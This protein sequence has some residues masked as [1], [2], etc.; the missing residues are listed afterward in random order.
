VPTEPEFADVSPTGKTFH[1]RYEVVRRIGA[2]GMAVVYQVLDRVTGRDRALKTMLPGIV[3]DRDLR[4]RFAQEVWVTAPVRSEHIVE[5]LDAGVDEET[6][7]PFIVMEFLAGEDLGSLLGRAGRLASPDVLRLLEQVARALTK[8][9]AANIVHRD[10]KPENLFLT[11]RDDGSPCVKVMDFGIAKVI[12]QHTDPRTTR[13]FG[14][15]L[16]MPPEQ[17]AGEGTIGPPADLYSLGH[18]AFALLTGRAYWETEAEG[19]KSP[20]ALFVQIGQGIT[21]PACERAAAHGVSLPPEFDRWFARATALDPGQRFGSALGMVQELA[22]A[23]EI[24]GLRPSGYPPWSLPD[25]VPRSKR[26]SR[27]HAGNRGS[28]S[29]VSTTEPAAGALPGNRRVGPAIVATAAVLGFVGWWL[30][31][32]HGAVKGVDTGPAAASSNPDRAEPTVAPAVSVVAGPSASRGGPEAPTPRAT[33]TATSTLSS[34]Q[35]RTGT[36]GIAR[37]AASTPGVP[38]EER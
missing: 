34:R 36:P 31:P 26:E 8:T 5:V 35:K 27:S 38:F 1:G 23:L 2:G 21:Q 15:P 25:P 16:Y 37:S 10:L 20:F 32:S 28:V 14:T 18:I 29:P 6:Q 30:W 17:I 9:H 7:L 19:A 13:S 22:S 11:R 4:S 24:S 12:A 3:S 33:R